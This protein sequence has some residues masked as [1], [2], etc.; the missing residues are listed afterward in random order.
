MV[1]CIFRTVG[2]NLWLPQTTSVVS[3]IYIIESLTR[4]F[5]V[6]SNWY[7]RIPACQEHILL[8]RMTCKNLTGS[9]ST[10]WEPRI[11]LFQKPVTLKIQPPK[12]IHRIWHNQP[13]IGVQLPHGSV[14]CSSSLLHFKQEFYSH[15]CLKCG[16][17][18][19][20]GWQQYLW[21][22][23]INSIHHHRQNSNMS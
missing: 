15:R 14:A 4:L 8:S 3:V 13:G 16:K 10:S 6:A 19:L 22:A 9:L 18:V 1:E 23:K 12:N 5:K 21:T 2:E 17:P 7:R 20:T 11:L